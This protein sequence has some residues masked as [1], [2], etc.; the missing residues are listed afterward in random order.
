MVFH[1]LVVQRKVSQK[2]LIAIAEEANEGEVEGL[3]T[4]AE[5]RSVNENELSEEEMLSWV[6]SARMLKKRVKRA[7]TQ[8]QE[9]YLW[10]EVIIV[11]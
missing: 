3:M 1:N 2:N 4:Y 10:K 11:I 9:T 5:V 8:T 7:R 6:R